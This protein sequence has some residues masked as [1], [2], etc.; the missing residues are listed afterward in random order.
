MSREPKFL[1][2]EEKQMNEIEVIW[3]FLWQ[4]VIV[5]GFVLGGSFFLIF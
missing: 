5:F 2:L 4:I 1:S 3:H